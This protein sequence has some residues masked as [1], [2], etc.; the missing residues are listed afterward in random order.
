[1]SDP[2]F[3]ILQAVKEGFALEMHMILIGSRCLC[4][5]TIEIDDF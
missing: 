2:F 4:L 3:P 5:N 1:M